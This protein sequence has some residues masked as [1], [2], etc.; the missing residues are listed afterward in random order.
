MEDFGAASAAAAPGECP[1][2]FSFDFSSAL[3]TMEGGAEAA[4]AADRLVCSSLLRAAEEEVAA[5]AAA[6]EADTEAEAGSASGMSSAA[7][8][9][10]EGSSSSRGPLGSCREKT[11]FYK[12]IAKISF[13]CYITCRHFGGL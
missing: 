3:V 1:G 8:A 4:E 13:K 9:A 10:A 5:P 12:N 7:E 11:K 2:T 6:S